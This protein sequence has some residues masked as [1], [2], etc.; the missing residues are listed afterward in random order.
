MW[1]TVTY[2][3]PTTYNA[4]ETLTDLGIGVPCKYTPQPIPAKRT[5]R[6]SSIGLFERW[7]SRFLTQHWRLC[8]GTLCQT[9]LMAEPPVN[10]RQPAQMQDGHTTSDLGSNN[11]RRKGRNR[12]TSS[13]RP[14]PR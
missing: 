8:Q 3:F 1:Y 5:S 9:L 10:N 7:T 14:S 11:G 12:P 2:P 6:R 13:R 4:S